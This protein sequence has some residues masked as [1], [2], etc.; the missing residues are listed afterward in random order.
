MEVPLSDGSSPSAG[1][2]N[3][4]SGEA[5]V[6]VQARDIG[7]L[8]LIVPH[9]DGLP[10][11]RQLP[12]SP[13]Q[14]VNRAV[15]MAALDDLVE[16]R[17]LGPA[18]AVITGMP[19]V[20]KSAIGRYWAHTVGAT[21]D[22]AH[23]YANFGDLRVGGGVGVSDVLGGFLRALGLPDAAIPPGLAERTA[24][25]R[26]ATAEMRM[27][28]FLDDVAHDAEVRPLIPS[29]SGAV[30]VVTSQGY[31]EELIVDGAGVVE[32]LPLS[33]DHA[34]LLLIEM[35]GPARVVA[36][37]PD[38]QALR[39]HCGGLPLALRMCAAWLVRRPSRTI[40]DL[41][42]TLDDR[43]AEP[44]VGIF[45]MAYG[46]L[47]DDLAGRY[48][49]LGL[50]PSSVLSPESAG[51]LW[52]S[53][54]RDALRCLEEL[55]ERHLLDV[56]GDR[57]YRIHGLVRAHARRRALL[58]DTSARIETV[59][60]R[61]VTWYLAATMRADRAI[62]PDRLRLAAPRGE[63][64]HPPLRFD[65]AADAFGWLEEERPTFVAVIEEAHRRGWHEDAWAMCEAL[66]PFLF[67]R[68]HHVD[69]VA[70]HRIGI[71][72]AAACED[73]YA[74]ARVRMQL[75]RASIELGQYEEAEEE[76]TE[77][78]RLAAGHEALSGSIMEFTGILCTESGRH[79]DA[80]QWLERSRDLYT[81]LGGRRAVLLQEFHLGR[82]HLRA[83]NPSQAIG[84][85]EAALGAVDTVDDRITASQIMIDLARALLA[86]G[87]VRTARDHLEE[88]VRLARAVPLPFD[89][90][91]A[92]VLLGQVLIDQGDGAGARRCWQRAH[93]LLV[94]VGSPDADAVRA[95][96][97]Q[98]G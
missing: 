23:L 77:A 80:V 63:A 50:L 9:P 42:A 3:W 26:S 54:E 5:H 22:E 29:S 89:E 20:G 44:I 83:G 71:E 75:A 57:R 37:S 31:L 27:L 49:D 98:I 30:V 28:V 33:P 35:I 60:R 86:E 67:N 38:V 58:E 25:Y 66:W 90:A 61:V 70:T 43:D 39:D 2:R 85:L 69:W 40:A 91:T 56:V 94:A 92:G 97:A 96:L 51:A 65:S 76:L 34:E 12:P 17:G 82:A 4:F 18:V 64:M 87:S 24:L 59:T 41:N 84:S 52:G 8:S 93:D 78:A 16:H 95:R 19:G 11:P 53:S 79:V 46:E 55:A 72:A 73:P 81:R 68:K 32:M 48:R 14:F 6:S 7:V 1:P 88:A 13:K 36:G 10:S 15:E 74:Q 62:L 45:D 21:F 47:P